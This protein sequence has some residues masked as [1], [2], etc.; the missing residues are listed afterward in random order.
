MDEF[1]ELFMREYCLLAKELKRLEMLFHDAAWYHFE[2][3]AYT[4]KEP[5]IESVHTSTLELHAHHYK[6]VPSR[7]GH[8]CEKAT[9]P[10]YYCGP[11]SDA[12]PLPPVIIL[13]EII[14]TRAA[15][16][17]AARKCAEVY[18]WAPGG[19]LYEEMLR[20]S[21]GARAYIALSSE[22]SVNSG[23]AQCAGETGTGGIGLLLGDRLER[24]A[25]QSIETTTDILLG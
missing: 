17:E 8:V 20:E 11:V 23:D 1:H 2:T 25:A 12:P 14:A 4:W 3:A 19:R 13:K 6:L 9:F 18:E 10:Y 7:G 16:E 24:E 22:R 15:V 5:W 21:P